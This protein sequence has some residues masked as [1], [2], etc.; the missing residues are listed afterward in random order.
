MALGLT[1]AT[2]SQVEAGER[3]GWQLDLGLGRLRTEPFL[4]RD[5]LGGT[6]GVGLSTPI[7]GPGRAC[8]EFRATAGGDPPFG[9]YIPE[10]ATAGEQS[11]VT[12]VGGLEFIDRRSLKGP[13]FT[14]G[15]GV[16]HSTITRAY[17]P[18]GS[19]NHFVPLH[20]RTAV[21]FGLGAGYRFTGGPQ[22]GLR[23]YGL[24][25]DITSSTAY[26]TVITVGYSH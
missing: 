5:A 13:V 21:A 22:L 17:G 10:A 11:L 26:S 19:P 24:P 18:T 3:I 6:I 7:R 23:T 25:R 9:T 1:L 20:D 16:G 4:N 15:L 12:L 2:E 8:F 14:L